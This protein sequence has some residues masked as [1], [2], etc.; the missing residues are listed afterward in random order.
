MQR[1]INFHATVLLISMISAFTFQKYHH[2][3]KTT[4]STCDNSTGN[5]CKYT[6]TSFVHGRMRE[7][8]TTFANPPGLLWECNMITFIMHRVQ[9][10]AHG[11]SSKS[12]IIIIIMIIIITILIIL[13]QYSLTPNSLVTKLW[14]IWLYLIANKSKEYSL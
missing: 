6:F 13:R 2:S 1:L 10:L 9:C 12:F 5:L 8:I 3:C 7:V 4:N 14:L 11:K